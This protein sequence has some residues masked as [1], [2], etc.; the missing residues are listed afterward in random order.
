MFTTSWMSP[1]KRR[2]TKRRDADWIVDDD[3]GYVKDG[4]EIFDLQ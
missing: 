4:R 1:S 2:V 3:G